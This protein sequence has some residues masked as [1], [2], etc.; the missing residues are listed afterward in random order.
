MR[1]KKMSN[2]TKVCRGY[3][4]QML[5]PWRRGAV[6]IASALGTDDPGLNPAWAQDFKEKT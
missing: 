4:V 3:D 6:D 1:N 2:L 5:C